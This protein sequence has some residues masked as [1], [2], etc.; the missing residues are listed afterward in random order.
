MRRVAK[1][2][3]AILLALVGVILLAGHACDPARAGGTRLINE[4][5]AASTLAIFTSWDQCK[6]TA[7]ALCYRER[8]KDRDYQTYLCET[9]GSVE[10]FECKHEGIGHASSFAISAPAPSPWTER[11]EGFLFR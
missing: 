3:G 6:E 2:V 7:T 5:S 9:K 10:R 1:I 8:A 4:K 11:Y